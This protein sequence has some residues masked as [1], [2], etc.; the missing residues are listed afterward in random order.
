MM[1]RV[2]VDGNRGRLIG[3][4]CI[5][6]GLAGFIGAFARLYGGIQPLGLVALVLLMSLFL[7]GIHLF[8]GKENLVFLRRLLEAVIFLNVI[9]IFW[10][11][12]GRTFHD[13]YPWTD[14]LGALFSYQSALYK[15]RLALLAL[16]VI[17]FRIMKRRYEAGEQKEYVFNPWKRFIELVYLNYKLAPL[18]TT[19][20]GVLSVVHTLVLTSSLT[21][22]WAIRDIL[23]T[24]QIGSELRF[25][26]PWFVA[27]VLVLVAIS[28]VGRKNA[29]EMDAEAA[30]KR[31]LCLL[32][33]MLI[34]RAVF[35]LMQIMRTL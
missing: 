13:F 35:W 28:Y 29:R 22:I 4:G 2:D 10:Y 6:I 33:V 27:H 17:D 32:V 26:L 7:Y 14:T 5:I 30:N 24:M 3:L 31:L 11:W 15:F 20:A 9:V 23:T 12:N 8:N 18:K 19:L 25:Y 1:G 21:R 16:F 34:L